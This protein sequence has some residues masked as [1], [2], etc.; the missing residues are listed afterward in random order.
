MYIYQ[1]IYSPEH[2]RAEW[3]VHIDDSQRQ[4]QNGLKKRQPTHLRS[5]EERA[6]ALR[7]RGLLVR[8]LLLQTV[9]FI[10]CLI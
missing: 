4:P 7:E 1:G 3:D 2:I 10:F 6:D 8:S 5:G 9:N